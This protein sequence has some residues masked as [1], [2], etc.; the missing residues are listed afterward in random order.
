MGGVDDVQPV[1][2]QTLGSGLLHHLVEQALEAL[3]P[4]ALPKAAEH[5]MIGRQLLGAQTQERLEEQVP[6]ALLLNVPVREIVEELQENHFE[7][8]HRV[9][10]VPTPGN[11]KV[12]QGRFDEGKVHGPRAERKWGR[13]RSSWS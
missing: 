13:R 8:E 11:V 6:G 4:Q 5:G 10:G 12:F 3:G 2:P 7:H 9:P 1:R